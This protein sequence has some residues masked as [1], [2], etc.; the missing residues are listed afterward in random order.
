MTRSVSCYC[1]KV[2]S[3]PKYGHYHASWRH[4]WELSPTRMLFTEF[5]RVEAAVPQMSGD[6]FDTV[7][8]EVAGALAAAEGK[9][10]KWG[11]ARRRKPVRHD[12]CKL[13]LAELLT[14]LEGIEADLGDM[15]AAV[16]MV[17][18][19]RARFSTLDDAEVSSRRTFVRS[20][21]RLA[22]SIRE[23]VFAHAPTKRAGS[24]P[25]G[26]GSAASE[27]EGLLRAE[28][29]TPPSSESGLVSV[30]GAAREE[31]Q[32]KTAAMNA[33]FDHQMQ[34]QHTQ[35]QE[36]DEVLDGLHSAVGRLKNMGVEMNDEITTQ[37]RMLRDLEA[38]VDTASGAM[39]SLKT[40]MKALAGRKDKGKLC[41]ILV[42]SGV[43]FGLTFL[44][45]YT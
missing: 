2:S 26:R 42:L 20:S 36:Q 30:G 33:A 10:A 11:E 13:L 3:I 7:R 12:E 23:D 29:S 4:C 38:Q 44:V 22:Q 31:S 17:E 34:M 39:D 32:H 45:I 21:M 27:R 35:E 14:V 25:A 16:T 9:H 41:T 18:R 6:P 43:L 40:K 1:E 24:S 8:A 19:N 37:N 28:A 15:D 5:F